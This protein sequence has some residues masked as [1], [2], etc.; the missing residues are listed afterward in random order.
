[1]HSS[2]LVYDRSFHKSEFANFWVGWRWEMQYLLGTPGKGSTF[3]LVYFFRT[4]LGLTDIPIAEF[5]E[6]LIDIFGYNNLKLR[7]QIIGE[8]VNGL[9]RDFW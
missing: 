8:L 7:T 2:K 6:L 5:L 9:L 1:M 3:Y 4:G